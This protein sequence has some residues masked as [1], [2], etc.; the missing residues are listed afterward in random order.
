MRMTFKKSFI[1]KLEKIHMLENETFVPVPVI[2]VLTHKM[3][4]GDHVV[5]LIIT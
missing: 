2:K 1:R 5:Y 3:L 4:S